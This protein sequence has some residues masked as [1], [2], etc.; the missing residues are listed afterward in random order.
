MKNL[1]RLLALLAAIAA[2]Y[3]FAINVAKESPVVHP[4]VEPEN[5]ATIE[6]IPAPTV[7]PTIE[8][9]PEVTAL[10]ENVIAVIGT[11]APTTAISEEI[12]TE[13][14]V[15][16]N[17]ELHQINVGCGDAYLLRSDKFTIMIDGGQK[18]SSSGGKNMRQRVLN[19][20][21]DVGV[22][23]IDAYVGTH[24]HGDHVENMIPILEKFA[25]DDT[26]VFGNS[27]K[28]PEKYNLSS[29]KGKYTQMKDGDVFNFG[30]TVIKC[31]GPYKLHSDENYNS[32]NI[33]VTHGETKI[34]MAG[35][36]IHSEVLDKHGEELK[37]I[38]VYKMAHHGLK[39]SDYSGSRAVLPHLN[40]DIILVPANSSGPTQDMV[41][42]FGIAAKVYDNKNGHI[43]VV[44]DGNSIA[45]T[46]E[47]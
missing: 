10:P 17:L 26:V 33:L 15:S 41:K 28:L 5:T 36:F 34:L 18:D 9:A 2:L 7:E 4:T 1:F 29:W 37:N 22:S 23:T 31:V 32:L 24:W 14:V 12:T 30:D 35:D 19:Y 46:T 45:V 20:L 27:S 42:N 43:I 40:P 3:F 16:G 21:E 25:N 39:V 11:P 47:K 6:I 38:D 13:V 44:S 8:P